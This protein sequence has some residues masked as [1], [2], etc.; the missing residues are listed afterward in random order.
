MKIFIVDDS[1]VGREVIKKALGLYGYND[2]EEA[3][4]GV[5]ALEQIELRKPLVDLFVLDINMPRM[6]GLTLLGKIR[7]IY[8]TTPVVMLTTETD[9]AKMVK[10][11]ESGATG[12]I[13][14]PFDAEKLVKV[15]QM[16][17]PKK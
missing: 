14:K 8:K 3:K 5:D 1:T 7:T 15:I 4:D 13:I 12:W 9:K 2:I 17:V 6:D 10:A 11:K 16:V